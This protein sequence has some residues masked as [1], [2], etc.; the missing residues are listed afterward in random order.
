MSKQIR[1][2][3]DENPQFDRLNGTNLRRSLLC[4][5]FAFVLLFAGALSPSVSQGAGVT[6]LRPAP[7]RY[8]DGGS[9][10]NLS[11]PDSRSHIV[12]LSCDCAICCWNDF[13]YTC[14]DQTC[15]QGC[16]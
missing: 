12:W 16:E 3:L 4:L 1:R 5:V 11:C 15:C 2:G 14:S 13:P 10:C 9:G 7:F 8:F 6:P